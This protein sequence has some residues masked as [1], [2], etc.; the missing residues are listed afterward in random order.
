MNDKGRVQ[1]LDSKRSS[2][3]RQSFEER[4]PLL[5]LLDTQGLYAVILALYISHAVSE[6]KTLALRLRQTGADGEPS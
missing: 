4:H 6:I 2:Q 5:K 1:V 3:A